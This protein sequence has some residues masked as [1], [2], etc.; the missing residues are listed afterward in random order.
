M[1]PARR[2]VSEADTQRANRR[3]WDAYADEYQATHGEFLRDVGF[4]WCPEGGRRG[5]RAGAR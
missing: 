2:T 4:I 3:D 1:Q 5:R